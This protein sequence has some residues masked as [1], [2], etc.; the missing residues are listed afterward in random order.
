MQQIC[1]QSLAGVRPLTANCWPALAMPTR[2]AV[3]EGRERTLTVSAE[4]VSRAVASGVS[5][6]AGGLAGGG[7]GVAV[8]VAVSV[9]ENW[10]RGVGVKVGSGVRVGKAVGTAVWP[11]NQPQPA[12]RVKASRAVVQTKSVCAGVRRTLNCLGRWDRR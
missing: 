1:H 7:S 4:M 10:L 8:S 11:P 2:A 3:V 12:S 6:G 5:V 9:A